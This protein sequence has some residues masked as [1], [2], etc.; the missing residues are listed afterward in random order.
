MVDNG[1]KD[2]IIVS[3]P[4]VKESTICKSYDKDGNK[5]INNYKILDTIGVGSYAKV[6]SV[7]DIKTQNHYCFKII[8]EYIL[9]RKKKSFTRDEEGNAIITTMLD[10]SKNE[11][12]V[13]KLL[14][15]ENIIKLYEI[16]KDSEN[17]KN[18]FVLELAEKGPLMTYDDN[19]DKFLLNKYLTEGKDYIPEKHIKNILL[20]IGHALDYLHEKNIVHRDIKPD[21]ILID[22]SFNAKLSDFSLASQIDGE[23]NFKKTEGNNYFYSPELC[24]GHKFFKAKPCDIWAYGVCAY[25]MVYNKLPILPENKLNLIEL[26]DMIGKGVVKY[27]EVKHISKELI[28]F[29]KQCLEKDPMKRLRAKEIVNHGYFK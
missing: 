1:N 9:E 2:Q 18:Y 5:I 8:N 19:T 11:E 22:A 26:F 17:R 24:Q 25:I 29:I 27:P 16:I 6:K 23:D 10:D 15:H 4:I 7:I 3:S 20:G 28:E 14:N 12:K 13:I 21:N